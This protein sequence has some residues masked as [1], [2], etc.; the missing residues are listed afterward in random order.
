VGSVRDVRRKDEQPLR[1]IIAVQPAADPA[2]VAEVVVK[3][4]GTPSP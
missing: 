4:T 2:R 3:A 1:G